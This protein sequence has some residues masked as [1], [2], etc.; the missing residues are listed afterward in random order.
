MHVGDSSGGQRHTAFLRRV[1]E[2]NECAAE[3]LP[4][5]KRSMGFGSRAIGESSIQV[6]ILEELEQPS[7]ARKIQVRNGQHCS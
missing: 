4:K 5:A 7:S 3:A 1:S 6:L 2:P